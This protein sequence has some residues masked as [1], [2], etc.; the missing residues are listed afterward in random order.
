MLATAIA[1]PT[2]DMGP[3]AR[4]AQLEDRAPG[5]HFLAES[6]EGDDDVLERQHLAAGRRSSAS[7]LTPNEVCSGVCW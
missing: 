3:L 6:D 1:R 2:Q 5:D 4:L 7:M